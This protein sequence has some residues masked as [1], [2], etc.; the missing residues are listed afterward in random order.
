[1]KIDNIKEFLPEKPVEGK[2]GY[3]PAITDDD[4]RAL[5][6]P[7]KCATW[8]ASVKYVIFDTFFAD[9]GFSANVEVHAE[10]AFKALFKLSVHDTQLY[11][12]VA[13]RLKS[14]RSVAAKWEQDTQTGAFRIVTL[15]GKVLGTQGGFRGHIPANCGKDKDGKWALYPK[16]EENGQI[17]RV[18][19]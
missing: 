18:A 16:S 13:V 17:V 19:F 10:Y 8:D 6:L 1:M 2:R 11:S 9:Y 7:M 4:Y 12:V 3:Y 15:S 14:G 5:P